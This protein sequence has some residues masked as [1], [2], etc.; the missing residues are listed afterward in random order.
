MR[1]RKRVQLQLLS[2]KTFDCSELCSKIVRG[3]RWLCGFIANA[4]SS[5]HVKGIH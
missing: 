1:Q 3:A 5:A 4:A 2:K